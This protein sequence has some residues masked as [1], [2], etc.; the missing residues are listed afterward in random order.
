MLWISSALSQRDVR[1]S[2]LSRPTNRKWRRIK[3]KG[4]AGQHKDTSLVYPSE[5]IT[6][7]CHKVLGRSVFF[8]HAKVCCSLNRILGKIEIKSYNHRL[9]SVGR[10]PR[11]SLNPPAGPAEDTPRITT[12]AFVRSATLF[13]PLQCCKNPPKPRK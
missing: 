1:Q 3:K 4:S 9:S 10:N 6:L 12:H 8:A 13:A 2:L 5:K 11:G 7:G